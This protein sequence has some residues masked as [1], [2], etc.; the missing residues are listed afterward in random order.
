MKTNKDFSDMISTESGP[1]ILSPAPFYI[2]QQRVKAIVLGTDPSNASNNGQRKILTKVFGIG[3][4]DPRYFMNILDNLK[5]VGLHLEDIYAD[6]LICDYLLSD[7]SRNKGWEKTAEYY[8][9]SCMARLRKIDIHKKIP[10]LVTAERLYKFLINSGPLKPEY[11][12]LHPEII[13][14]LPEDNK[15]SRP[16]IPFFRNKSYSLSHWTEY[17]TKLTSIFNSSQ[18]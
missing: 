17:K 5:E 3:D 6:N 18:G 1:Q 15:L 4:S 8:L 14:I 12:Y 7:T 16:L 2:N 11:I 10:V 13:P 9:D